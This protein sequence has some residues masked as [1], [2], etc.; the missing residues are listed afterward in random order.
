VAFLADASIKLRTFG[1]E[2]LVDLRKDV[3]GP[4]GRFQAVEAALI[5]RLLPGEKLFDRKQ[6]LHLDNRFKLRPAGIGQV[7]Q[8]PDAERFTGIA[9]HGLFD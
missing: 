1:G 2:R 5:V 3:C 8:G 4:F 9:H 6:L 7:D